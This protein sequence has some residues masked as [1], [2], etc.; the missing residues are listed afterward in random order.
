MVMQVSSLLPTEESLKRLEPES[1]SDRDYQNFK[2]CLHE[3]VSG[4]TETLPSY[5]SPYPFLFRNPQFSSM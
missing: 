5:F 3:R 4:K 2:A 1:Q